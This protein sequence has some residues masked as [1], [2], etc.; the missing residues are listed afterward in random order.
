MPRWRRCARG[1]AVEFW[2]LAAREA[3][4][5]L[6]ARYAQHADG[7]RFAELVALF[8]E[9]GELRIDDRAPLRGREAILAFLHSI[10]SSL[11]ESTGPRS[12]RHHVTTLRIEVTGPAAAT[13]AAYFLVVTDRGAD[14]WGRY[15]DRYA[16][17]E[18]RWLFAERQVRVDGFAQGSPVA[19]R[20]ATPT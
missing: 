4:R 7:G 17:H 12:M 6:V 14:H 10:R 18:G 5:E 19:A 15:R 13:G 20:R 1:D 2:E 3:I 9:D 16:R 8:T 11:R